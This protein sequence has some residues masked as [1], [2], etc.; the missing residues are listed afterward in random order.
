VDLNKGLILDQ[1]QSK[2]AFL[3]VACGPQEG[4]AGRMGMPAGRRRVP[5]DRWANSA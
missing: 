1:K 2:S 5:A 4:H 3:Q